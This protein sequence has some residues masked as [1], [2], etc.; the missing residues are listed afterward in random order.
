MDRLLSVGSPMNEHQN[1]TVYQVYLLE[2]DPDAGVESPVI[3]TRLDF[4]DSGVWIECDSGRDFFP[5][6]QVRVVRERPAADVETET[7]EA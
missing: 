1:D 2:D 4:F 3:G 5:Y 7:I 6:E